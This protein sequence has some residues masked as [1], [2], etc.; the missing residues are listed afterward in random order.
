ML[1]PKTAVNQDAGNLSQ[2]S[3][4]Q[5]AWTLVSVFT[6]AL[7]AAAA[8]VLRFLFLARKPFWF[9]ESFSVEIA[10]LSWHDFV[11]LLWWR[12]A[13]MSFYYVVL[14]GWLHFG[15][16]PFFIRSFSVLVSLATLPAIFWLGSRLFDRRVGLIA[17]ALISC[18]VY[19]IRYAQEARSYSL[20]VLLA[21]LSS[22]FFVA[23]LR[24]LSSSGRNRRS[25]ILTSVLAVYTHFYALLLVAAHWLSARGLE[26]SQPSEPRVATSRGMNRT[27]IALAWVW[28][29]I[30]VLP[31]AVFVGKTGAGQI[32]WIARPG[33]RDLLDF[34]E[35]LAGNA[36]L[37]LLLLYAAAC[38]AAVL[39]LRGTLLSLGA[40]REVWRLQFLLIWL[41]FPV[42]LTLLLSLVRPVFLARYLAFCLPALIILAAAGLSRLRKTWLLAV[43]LTAMLLLSL[44]GT[45]SYY[46][47]DFDLERDGS[48]AA[49]NYIFDHAQPGDAILFHFAEA[50]IPYEFVRSLR[51]AEN[52]GRSP[53]A[54]PEIIFPRHGNHLDYRDVTG[55]PTVE[56]MHSVSGQYGRVWVVLMSNGA[57]GQ[58][59]ATTLMLNQTLATSFSRIELVQFPRVEV[60]LYSMR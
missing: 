46:D 18:N 35:H 6:L 24:G 20:F 56:F 4:A 59:D 9:D 36:G 60:W 41:F 50:R 37:A 45:L 28:I 14:R 47:H 44:Q 22:G 49:A 1:P 2:N 21:T 27:S 8:T 33:V 40:K 43:S 39:P 3:S 42:I 32:R 19:H 10:R 12:E 23:C 31:V 25:Y 34:W 57:P 54:G 51:E 30:A 11:R 7:L 13:N 52:S 15:L 29:G 5:P 55:N 17:V 53:A 38:L 48:Q 26:K 16:N 58:P